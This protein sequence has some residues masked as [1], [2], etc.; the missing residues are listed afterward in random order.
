LPNVSITYGHMVDA[1]ITNGTPAGDPAL[2]HDAY[3]SHADP[4]NG[5][6]YPIRCAV[7]PRRQVVA[8]T[9][10]NGADSPRHFAVRYRDGR[11]HRLGRGFLGFGERIVTDLDTGAGTADFYDNQTS[12]DL[13]SVTVFPTGVRGCMHAC[14]RIGLYHGDVAGPSAPRAE[15]GRCPLGPLGGRT[16][17]PRRRMAER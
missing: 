2:E 11:Y 5:C 16:P 13:G 9:T 14:A 10:N 8:Y 12:Q 6:A 17:L 1:S 4:A 7:G 3:L 15:A